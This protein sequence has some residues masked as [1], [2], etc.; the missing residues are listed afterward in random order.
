MAQSE[1]AVGLITTYPTSGF[2]SMYDQVPVRSKGFL[3]SGCCFALG[4]L[5][6]LLGSQ[7]AN[8]RAIK[9]SLNH[10]PLPVVSH[11]GRLPV[12]K[13]CYSVRGTSLSAI[14]AQFKTRLV[15]CPSWDRPS[16]CE[17]PQD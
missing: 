1:T 5:F 7:E 4:P 2:F 12:Y 14:L 15:E 6:E 13:V 8:D 17:R 11:I 16:M 10:G 9:P 3:T